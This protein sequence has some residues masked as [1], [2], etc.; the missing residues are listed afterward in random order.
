MAKQPWAKLF[1]ETVLADLELKSCSLAARGMWVMTFCLMHRSVRRGF[2]QDRAGKPLTPSQ[3][4]SMAGCSVEE[5]DHCLQELLNAG[6]YS[7]TETGIIYCRG[8][9]RQTQISEV[10]AEAGKKGA[11]V[12]NLLRQ[13]ERQ[14]PGKQVGKQVGK[15]LTL[16]NDS[17]SL[18]KEFDSITPRDGGVGEGI[19]PRQN[20]GK[21]DSAADFELTPQGISTAWMF[22]RRGTGKEKVQEVTEV[23]ESLVG[24]IPAKDLLAAI[25]SRGDKTEYLWQFKKRMLAS[26]VGSTDDFKKRIEEKARRERE[27]R[28]NATHD[29]R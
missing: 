9:V 19:L 27:E 10:R 2:L 3:L 28:E 4:A 22:Y 26:P 12:A 29:R 15:P 13:N 20:C 8:M 23:M 6:V 11:G 17:S 24:V 16:N 7:A 25:V 1:T 18:E 5:A 14:T 21:T